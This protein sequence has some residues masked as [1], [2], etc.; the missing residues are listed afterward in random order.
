MR[1]DTSNDQDPAEKNLGHRHPRSSFLFNRYRN[2]T[3]KYREYSSVYKKTKT[4]NKKQTDK[5]SEQSHM[6]E[7]HKP[8]LK[9]S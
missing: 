9:H 8:P 1:T 7:K 3:W 2:E 4:Q 5:N 6:E